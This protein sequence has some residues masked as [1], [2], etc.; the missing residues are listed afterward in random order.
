MALRWSPLIAPKVD[1]M[2]LPPR[3][4]AQSEAT[5]MTLPD[6]DIGAPGQPGMYMVVAQ[7]AGD[8]RNNEDRLSDR[9][10][11][12]FT[13]ELQL[14]KRTSVVESYHGGFT[15]EDCGSLLEAPAEAHAMRFETSEGPIDV[16]LNARRELALM[17]IRVLATDA[18]VARD[19]AH[20]AVGPALDHL[21][22]IAPAPIL[23]DMSR[24]VD[25]RNAVTYLDVL[26]PDRRVV[27]N[28]GAAEVFAEL[29]PIYGLYREFKNASSAYYRL[30]CLYKILEGMF[31]VLRREAREAAA[32]LGVELKWPK[33]RVPPCPELADELQAHVGSPI[34]TFFDRVVQK[35]YRDVVAHFLVHGQ[36]ALSPSSSAERHRFAQMAYLCDQCA[37]IVIDNHADVLRQLHAARARQPGASSPSPST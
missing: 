31:S 24:I 16:E 18:V 5:T 19:K 28:T 4:I 13:V 7:F 29:L 12:W 23:I 3:F 17:R 1:S 20:D 11:R 15:A 14:T 35:E 26:G 27:L 22:Y 10:A 36:D 30:L 33:E 2:G 25:E 37:R 21:A 8:T 6:T 32:S 34:A 9:T